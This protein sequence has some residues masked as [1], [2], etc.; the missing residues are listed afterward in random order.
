[1]SQ[2]YFDFLDANQNLTP[3]QQTKAKDALA[4][5]VN[6][7]T[8]K[9]DIARVLGR[10]GLL[11]KASSVVMFAPRFMFSRLQFMNPVMYARAPKGARKIM[12]KTAGKFYG[13]LFGLLG[14]LA[15][16]GVQISFD[17]ED[18]D[19]LKI[20]IPGTDVKYDL[21]AGLKEPMRLTFGLGAKVMYY[22]AIGDSTGVGRVMDNWKDSQGTFWR[23]KLSPAA[24][25]GYDWATDEDIAGKPFSMWNATTGRFAPIISQSAWDAMLN[26]REDTLMR[27]PDDF[28]HFVEKLH[29]IKDGDVNVKALAAVLPAEMFGVGTSS[30]YK[31]PQSLAEK[32]FLYLQ[33]DFDSE[34]ANPEESRIKT[35]LRNRVF[36]GESRDKIMREAQGYLDKGTISEKAFKA[37]ETDTKLTPLQYRA[38]KGNLLA[39]LLVYKLATERERREIKDT[40]LSKISNKKN[41]L[42]EQEKALMKDLGFT[43]DEPPAKD[44]RTRRAQRSRRR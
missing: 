28:E 40:V 17:P 30:F 26:T 38:K 44:T 23:G 16:A 19:F 8:G 29:R 18:K 41:P 37:V 11:E 27:E 31:R 33:P 35:G 15:A 5:F 32:T 12:L 10:G 21:T 14:A 43:S 25:F 7:I 22:K 24:S 2:A 36:A 42:T 9:G 4:K 34:P 6:V 1:L 20:P 13:A 39:N 3:E